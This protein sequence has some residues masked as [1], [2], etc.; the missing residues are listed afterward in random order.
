MVV[1]H[2]AIL[3]DYDLLGTMPEVDPEFLAV[4]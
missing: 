4:P 2:A 1:S 3:S